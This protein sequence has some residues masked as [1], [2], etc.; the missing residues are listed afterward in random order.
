MLQTYTDSLNLI[1]THNHENQKQNTKN[2][3][4]KGV[5]VASPKS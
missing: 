4:S 3:V 5:D 1:P 2:S